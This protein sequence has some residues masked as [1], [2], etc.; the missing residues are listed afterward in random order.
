MTAARLVKKTAGR[1]SALGHL[2]PT[3]S[4]HLG[5]AVDNVKVTVLWWIVFLW[6][7]HLL[8]RHTNRGLVVLSAQMMTKMMT[9]H[10]Q[11]FTALIHS[12]QTLSTVV[13]A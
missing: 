10:N 13:A 2:V 12:A 4:Y 3:L 11:M 9:C 1:G 5:N 7:A 8:T 6:I